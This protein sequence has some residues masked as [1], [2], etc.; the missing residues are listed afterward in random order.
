[1]VTYKSQSR[2]PD[3]LAKHSALLDSSHSSL[4][5]VTAFVYT[6]I[7]RFSFV[8]VVALATLS[9]AQGPAPGHIWP[10]DGSVT[11]TVHDPNHRPDHGGVDIANDT[12]TPILSSA[13]GTVL[14]AGDAGGPG[15]IEVV[16]QHPDGTTTI[17][18]HLAQQPNVVP[19]QQVAQGQPIGIMG[20]TGRSTG[21]HLHYEIRDASGNPLM[22]NGQEWDDAAGLARGQQITAGASTP[23][24]GNGNTGNSGVGN[25]QIAANAKQIC[26]DRKT[27]YEVNGG[28]LIDYPDDL[29]QKCITEE[30]A[31]LTQEAQNPSNG[32]PVTVPPINEPF[33]VSKMDLEKL[34]PTPASWLQKT[35]DIM[36]SFGLARGLNTLGIALLF[37]CFVYSLMNATYF[38]QSDQYFQ[39]FGRLIIAGALVLGSGVI[40]KGV[41]NMWTETYKVMQTRIIEPATTKLEK[42]LNQLGP[43]LKNLALTTAGLNT[44]A[45][46]IPDIAGVDVGEEV[47]KNFA[48]LGAQS[49][50]GLFT[51]MVLMGSIY[52]VYFLAI[53]VSGMIALLAGVLIPILAPFL[54]LPGSS[55]WFTRWFSM[56]F[57]SLVVVVA[58]PFLFHV[59]VE[60]GVTAP[61]TE[62]NGIAV[63]MQQQTDALTAQASQHP[64]DIGSIINPFAWADYIKNMAIV[65]KQ[66]STNMALLY[67]QWGFALVLLAISILASIYLMQQLPKLLQGFIGGA[68]GSAASPVSGAALGG[69]LAG[70]AV[71]A[72]NVGNKAMHAG[73]NAVQGGGKAL[74]GGIR[75]GA[76]AIKNKLSSSGRNDSSQSS[77]NSNSTKPALPAKSSAGSNGSS[78]NSSSQVKSSKS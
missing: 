76:G 61:M 38:Y 8:I 59:V 29:Y 43:Q 36:E 62:V 23:G 24:T 28:G 39:I 42:N 17:Y 72:G 69:M 14:S 41:M 11:G 20:S 22:V 60:L 52:G 27:E 30:T 18:S 26:D 63:Q 56:V 49:I 4:L 7:L 5:N 66:V 25:S 64:K 21:P 54:V 75:K 19:G 57:L 53:Y 71:G 73:G 2:I 32:G 77:S 1:M 50:R 3:D 65:A 40:G 12:G 74:A 55:S 67:I 35:Q 31:R 46:I 34:L 47:A 68:F 9:Y 58:F 13:N 51:V 15:G 44:L 48:D 33:D 6:K 10:T 45:A 16:I 78:N 37:G 70:A